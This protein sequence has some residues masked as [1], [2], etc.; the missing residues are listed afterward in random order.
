MRATTVLRTVSRLIDQHTIVRDFAVDTDRNSIV[1]MVE[2]A[3]L[4]PFCSSC[5]CRVEKVYDARE[6]TWRHTDLER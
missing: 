1:L 4:I 6:R 5:G 3:T 2:P